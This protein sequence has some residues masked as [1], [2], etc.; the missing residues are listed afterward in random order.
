MAGM[1]KL[2]AAPSS[3]CMR[4]ASRL[5]PNVGM[6]TFRRVDIGLRLD[7]QGVGAAMEGVEEEGVMAEWG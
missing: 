1:G 7:Y 2:S 5:M 4:T 6:A 3:A